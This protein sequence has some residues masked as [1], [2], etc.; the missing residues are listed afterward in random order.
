MIH[1]E[2]LRTAMLLLFAQ[3][4]GLVLVSLALCAKADAQDLTAGIGICD[5]VGTT[6]QLSPSRYLPEQK[7]LEF[8]LVF[9]PGLGWYRMVLQEATGT[10]FEFEI[11]ELSTTGHKQA[12]PAA[13]LPL[14]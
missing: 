7:R 12:S 5:N 14:G 2:S 4:A 9:A 13:Y 8:P 6:G 3:L 11:K 1:L 10:Q